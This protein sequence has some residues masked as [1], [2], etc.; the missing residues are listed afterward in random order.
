MAESP[1]LTRFTAIL[2]K[3]T[4]LTM[5]LRSET[6]VVRRKIS[7]TEWNP[8]CRLIRADPVGQRRCIAC[9]QR[10]QL[11]AAKSGVT[12]FYI[13]HAGFRDIAVPI[14]AFGR[15][16]ATIF[17]GQVLREPKSPA[18]FRR[19]RKRLA[20]LKVPDRDL[21]AAYDRAIYLSQDQLTCVAQMLE[22]F[23]RQLCESA[24]RI[25]DLEA[26]LERPEVRRGRE[27]VENHFR[28]PALSLADA[29]RHACLA[30]AHF[31][32]VFRQTTGIPF[33][34]FVQTRRIAEAKKQLAE[35]QASITEICFACGFSSLSHFNRVFRAFE[36]Q[37][38]RQY[39]QLLLHR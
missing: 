4:G 5:G 39:R 9:N 1:E 7:E 25:R 15:H 17:T 38:P 12:Q 3:L 30:P 26:Q 2:H 18:A 8:I 29:A 23:A 34:R 37:S 27:F 11:L 19:L 24:Q 20:W 32:H 21:R 36:H 13:C 22:M 14:F 33:T 16:V 28:D 6:G 31:S 10:H 35:T